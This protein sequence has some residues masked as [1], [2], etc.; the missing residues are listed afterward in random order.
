MKIIQQG[1]V[2]VQITALNNSE[3]EDNPGATVNENQVFSVQVAVF[4]NP[5]NANRVK[6]QVENSWI[7]IYLRGIE[8]YRVLTDNYKNFKNVIELR[9]KVRQNGFPDAFVVVVSSAE[10]EN[11]NIPAKVSREFVGKTLR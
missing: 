7:K 2:R 5:E 11:N 9:Y 6:N 3:P 1:T 10:I 4:Q 8:S